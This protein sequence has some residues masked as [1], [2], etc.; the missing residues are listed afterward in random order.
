MHDRSGW[1]RAW[2][3]TRLG[4]LLVLV[5]LIIAAAVV[6]IWRKPIADDYIRDELERRGVQATYT[7]DRVGFRTQQVSNLVIGDPANPDLTVRRAIIQIRIKWNGSVEVYRVVAR[8]V[9]LKGRLLPSGKVSWG[10]IDKLLPP[11]S[12][13]PFRLPDLGR[14]RGHDDRAGHAVRADGIRGRRARAICRAGSPAS[15]RPRRPGLTLGACR[16]DQFR[17]FVD[18][19]VIA[20]RPQVKGPI[21]AQG[22]R[23]PGQQS[24]PR[25]AA[26]GNRFQLLRRRSTASTAAAG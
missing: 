6:W 22:V 13:K 4:L 7:L 18:I 11:P 20:R 1:H 26:D 16:L 23:L 14:S 25:P 21:G 19:G 3:L 12:G 9:R 24:A 17:A 5:L 15:W 10:Q 8:G 2:R